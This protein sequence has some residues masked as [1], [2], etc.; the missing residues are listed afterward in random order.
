MP[1]NDYLNALNAYDQ[2]KK[3]AISDP[4]EIEIRALLKAAET[5][6][7]LKENWDNFKLAERED[8][9]KKNEKLW[10][11]FTSEMQKDEVG[12]DINIRNNIANLGIYIFK[13]TMD[14]RSEPAPEK[15]N[16]LININRNIAAGLQDSIEFTKKQ[17]AQQEAQASKSNEATPSQQSPYGA[18]PPQEHDKT[19]IDI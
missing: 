18:P 1:N 19:D 11:I 2:A 10:T 16:I 14:I 4:R 5:L 3:Q 8:I 12:L 6:Q 7:N 13:R 9:L 15:L 17:R